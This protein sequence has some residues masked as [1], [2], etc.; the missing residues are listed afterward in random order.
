[1]NSVVEKVCVED[2]YDLASEIGKE[3]E[4][5]IDIYGIEIITSL[6]PKV[7]CALEQLEFC[8]SRNDSVDLE[9][10]DLNSVIVQ[11]QYEKIGK[12]EYKSKL[13]KELE[14]IEDI[15]REETN[16]LSEL[17]TELKEEN[18]RLYSSLKEKEN[19]LSEKS[20]GCV[21][22]QD[23]K[24]A[25]KLKEIV[26]RQREQIEQKDQELHHKCNDVEV[27]QLQLQEL[28]QFNKDLQSKQKY[29]Q[30]QMKALVEEK[31]ELQVQLEEYQ[32]K[33]QQLRSQLGVAVKENLE[34]AQVE[35][36]LVLDLQR[37]IVI[38]LDDPERLQL[39]VD[40]I[41]RIMCE[42]NDLKAKMNEL[43]DELTLCKSQP[44]SKSDVVDPVQ[45]PINKEPEEKLFPPAKPLGI[46]RFF[47]FVLR[48]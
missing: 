18:L 44:P 27:L 35:N 25:Q 11:L 13:E 28:V 15:W 30:C 40:E 46:R 6:M 48:R 21:S 36:E 47:Q 19:I 38:D 37:K 45:G 20:S 17:V 8:A 32:R 16:R 4:K 3:F 42:R 29:Q 22:E 31:M 10:S 24:I 5:I 2:V 9:I 39:T 26:D 34:L 33:L 12:Q 41:K 43:Q 1:M 23:L 7:I 14:Q